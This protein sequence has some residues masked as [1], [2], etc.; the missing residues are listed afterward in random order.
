MTCK[1]STDALSP[2]SIYG[3]GAYQFYIYRDCNL[4]YSGYI[5]LSTHQE[6]VN[7]IEKLKRQYFEQRSTRY[8]NLNIAKTLNVD[9]IY[10]TMTEELDKY[11]GDLC[12]YLI[13]DTSNIQKMNLYIYANRIDLQKFIAA[14]LW[15]TIWGKCMGNVLHSSNVNIATIKHE[16]AHSI[17]FQKCGDY[18]NAFFDEG[19][20][21][22]TEY[23]FNKDIFYSDREVTKANLGL[24]TKDLLMGGNN[25][26]SNPQNYPI[27]GVFTKYI[28]DKIN[29]Q[30]FKVCFSQKNLEKYLS[31]NFHLTMEELI[32]EFKNSLHIL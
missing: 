23:L 9:S 7:N 13:M 20:R 26:Y 32:Q 30:E 29:F 8:F 24:L 22:Y 5:N 3:V 31:D 14:P 28:I 27:S 17:I 19:F 10:T 6:Q 11:T 25:F 16:T 4:Y 12:K 1:N 18:S 15:S 21:Q 2:F